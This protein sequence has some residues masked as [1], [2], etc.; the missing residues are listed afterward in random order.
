MNKK[1]LKDLEWFYKK[2]IKDYEKAK[3]DCEQAEEKAKQEYEEYSK[4]SNQFLKFLDKELG[5]EPKAKMR[6]YEN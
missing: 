6:G 1:E 3:K 4:L 5:T 2:S